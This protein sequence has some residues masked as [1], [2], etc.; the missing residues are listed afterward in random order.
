MKNGFVIEV[1]CTHDGPAG[2]G[3]MMVYNMAG[4]LACAYGMLLRC[5]CEGIIVE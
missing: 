1:I 2:R 5:V 4:S 3:Y